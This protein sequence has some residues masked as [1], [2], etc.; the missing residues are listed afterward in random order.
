MLNDIKKIIIGVLGFAVVFSA[1]QFFTSE[2]IKLGAAPYRIERTLIPE[3]DSTY[4]LGTTTRRWR[5]GYFDTV[6]ATNYVGITATTTWGTI[7]GTITDQTDLIAYA[8]S[9]FQ[10]IGSYL[11]D[12]TDPLSLHLDQTTPQTVTGGSPVFDDGITVNDYF[13]MNHDLGGGTYANFNNEPVPGEPNFVFD[14][15]K[16]LGV[17]QVGRGYITLGTDDTAVLD[18]EGGINF[19]GYVAFFDYGNVDSNV[20]GNYVHDDNNYVKVLDR[21][22]DL[23]LRVKGGVRLESLAGN[24]AGVVAVDDDGNLSFGAGGAALLDGSNQP[25]TGDLTISKTTPKLT[26]TDSGGSTGYL[27]LDNTNDKLKIGIGSTIDSP[28]IYMSPSG[29]APVTA[30][31]NTGGS[32]DRRGWVT[33][34][35]NM[36]YANTLANIIDGSQ[37]NNLYFNTQSATGKYLR[38]DFG[39]GANY[40]IDNFK[41]YYNG[42]FNGDGTWKV[43]GS[44]DGSNWTDVSSNF[45]WGG[46]AAGTE[47]SVDLI[48]SGYRYYQFLGVSGNMTDGYYQREI[49]FKIGVPG[50]SAVGIFTSDTT[51]AINLSGT[52]ATDDDI[53]IRADNKK[54]YFGAGDDASIYYDGTNML[55]N[56]KVVGTGI[57]DVAGVL[58]TDGYNSSDGTAGMT[59]TRSFNDADGNAHAVT[60]KNGLITGWVVTPP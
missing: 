39:V 31:T 32:G 1:L 4:D 13:S 34:S 30:Y 14:I 22:N 29:S 41:I 33:V 2:D 9:T 20:Y 18:L 49:T 48:D 5:T 3:T 21:T 53:F 12:E 37:S 25:F 46:S 45:T 51:E 15:V 6:D 55:I 56:P 24:G 38:F 54:L 27:A 47:F 17:S 60:I 26:L 57:L 35:T 44:N 59:D 28:H 19:P 40:W 42:T 7:V 16:Y 52:T 10:P 36:T 11:T 58:Q 50:P 23:A 8:T 43:Q